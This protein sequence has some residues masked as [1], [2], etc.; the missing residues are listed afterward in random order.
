MNRSQRNNF[1]NICRICA[2]KS[3]D[4]LGLFGIRKQGI[5]LADMISVCTE[6]KIQQT[7]NRPSN[8]CVKC[9]SQLV[10]AFEFRKMAQD[11][12]K[13]FQSMPVPSEFICMSSDIDDADASSDMDYEI[14]PSSSIDYDKKPVKVVKQEK[15]PKKA[16]KVK[17]SIPSPTEVYKHFLA[18]E[19]KGASTSQRQLVRGPGYTVHRAK[20]SY[21]CYKCKRKLKSFMKLR[22]HMGNHLEFTPNECKICGMFFSDENFAQHL[23]RGNSVQCEYCSQSFNT[24]LTLLQHLETKQCQMNLHRCNSCPKQFVMSYLLKC[25]SIR[26]AFMLQRFVCNVCGKGYAANYQLTQHKKSHSDEKRK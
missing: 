15:P 21:E 10:S 11:S 4:T 19:T 22:E 12:E 23:C 13:K 7:D 14:E 24:T 26:H 3:S 6:I 17:R 20:I 2:K 18:E 1:L 25:H 9:I 5:L 8:I 16:T